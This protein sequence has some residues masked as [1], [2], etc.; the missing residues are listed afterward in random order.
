MANIGGSHNDAFMTGVNHA[1]NSGRGNDNSITL[2]DSADSADSADQGLGQASAHWNGMTPHG[3]LNT[4]MTAAGQD[5]SPFERMGRVSGS[6]QP[7]QM[8][9]FQDQV[10]QGTD[11]NAG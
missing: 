2:N 1:A 4:A 5:D 3:V 8:A 11:D 9:T 10:S 6:Y 7:G